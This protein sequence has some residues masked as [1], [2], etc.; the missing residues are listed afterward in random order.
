M[1]NV[2]NFIKKL[3]DV[4]TS[5]AGYE[6]WIEGADAIAFLEQNLL[7]T[8]LA[9]A[10]HSRYVY[11]HTVLVRQSLTDP[12]PVE[13]CLNWDVNSESTWS[14]SV[15]F[16]DPPQIKVEPPL[17]STESKLFDGAEQI[18]YSREFQ[19]SSGE[20]RY[21]EI[22]QKFLHVM[23]LHHVPER[24]AWCKLDDNGDIQNVIRI[25]TLP[26]TQRDWEGEAI[27]ID[28]D[29]LDRYLALTEMS[30]LR[31][32]DF[33][34]YPTSGFT[35]WHHDVEDKTIVM[36]TMAYRSHVQRNDASYLR[37][38]Q[39]VTPKGQRDLIRKTCASFGRESQKYASFI[40]QDWRHDLIVEVS[41]A[42]GATANY[43]VKSDLPFE[44]SPAFFRPEVLAKYKADTTKYS[45]EDR[46]I[47]CRGAWSLKGF[48]VNEA[49]QVH[50]RV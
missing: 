14:V 26:A 33:T 47:Y 37:G 17:S 25:V 50:E 22:S 19:G 9:I 28:R 49:G 10:I 6:A 11:C 21:Y 48:D 36:E 7:D 13:E 31:T 1:R 38:A 39:V 44:L 30:A 24:K 12:F 35:S 8:E 43:F 29:L 41:C 46:R 40:V 45:I 15:R 23:D 32:F 42:P 4:P 2:A 5:A 34:R 20:K 3:S 27:L 18:I 16:T